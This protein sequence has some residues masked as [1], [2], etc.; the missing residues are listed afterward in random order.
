MDSIKKKLIEAMLIP[1]L[2][3][4]LEQIFTKENYQ[5][6]GDRLFD[7]IEEFVKDTK[8]A[9]DDKVVLPVVKD[10]RE[11]MNIPDDASGPEAA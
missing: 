9:I 1:A 3:M 8:T 6:Y 10:L 11:F 4:I 2:M 5:H 7:L